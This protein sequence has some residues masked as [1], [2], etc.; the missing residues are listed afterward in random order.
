VECVVG[1][2]EFGGGLVV[3]CFAVD[4]FGGVVFPRCGGLDVVCV[5]EG[6]GWDGHPFQDWVGAGFVVPGAG[7]D[8]GWLGGERH[9]WDGLWKLDVWIQSW[10]RCL[11]DW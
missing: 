4:D 3:P 10:S 9:G 6:R 1:R 11:L 2:E 8:E 7:V 5:W